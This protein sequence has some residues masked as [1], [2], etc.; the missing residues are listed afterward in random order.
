LGYNQLPNFINAF[1]RRFGIAP[2][3]YRR[4]TS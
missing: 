4:R 2:G 3:A 1:R